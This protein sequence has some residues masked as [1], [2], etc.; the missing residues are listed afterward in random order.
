MWERGWS[1]IKKAG[2]VIL[3]ATIFVWFASSFGWDEGAF[4]MVD[5]DASILAITGSAIAWLFAPLGWAN[6]QSAVAS[7]T[8]L[9]AKENV[10]GTFGIL[11]GYAEV[12]EDGAELWT[13]LAAHFS[14]LGAYSF[15]VFNLLCAPCFAAMGAIKREMNN[16]KW[17]WIAVGYQ[18]GFA[19]LVSLCVYQL[20]MLF[21][22]GAFG[23]GTIAA[24]AL[25]GAFLF[26]LFRPAK[27]LKN[28]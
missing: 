12:A 23:P 20:G 27:E 26:F 1:F 14:V 16:R 2:T 9:I 11:F 24:F 18:C 3:L 10:V 8:G 21:G 6:W 13:T 17:F 7:I 19:Y 15:L 4:G 28:G 22:A 25:T 5:M